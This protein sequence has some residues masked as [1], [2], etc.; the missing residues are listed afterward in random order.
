MAFMN[1]VDWRVLQTTTQLAPSEQSGNHALLVQCLKRTD[2]GRKG[3]MP[4]G[5]YQTLAWARASTC[6]VHS[7][8]Y[9][10]QASQNHTVKSASNKL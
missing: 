9:K 3:K 7:I 8:V 1:Y 6:N 4:T 10:G 2:V 5:K